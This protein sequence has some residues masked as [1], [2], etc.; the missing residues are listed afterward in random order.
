[1]KGYTTT[2]GLTK[3]IR[4]E[5]DETLGP[6]ADLQEI[7]KPEEHE[8]YAVNV[9]LGKSRLPE[10]TGHMAQVLQPWGEKGLPTDEKMLKKLPEKQQDPSIAVSFS[11]KLFNHK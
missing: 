8:N 7:Q 9:H 11:S 10:T 1:M 6:A 4:Y 3:A 5:A 2:F